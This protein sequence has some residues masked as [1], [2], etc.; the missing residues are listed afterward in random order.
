[1]PPLRGPSSDRRAIL[2]Q[3][4]RQAATGRRREQA[5]QRIKLAPRPDWQAKAEAV[6]FTWHHVSG[7]LYWDE[8]AAYEFSMAEIEWGIEAPTAELHS[9][10]LD[11]VD[12]AVQSERL[13]TLLDI[14]EPMR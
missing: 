10:C 5:M 6:G 12:E 7:D 14:P 9:M 8:S 13:M 3:P 2:P 1:P 11:L 4:H